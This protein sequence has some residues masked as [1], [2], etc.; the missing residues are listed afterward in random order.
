MCS[1]LRLLR[2]SIGL[3]AARQCVG[4]GMKVVLADVNAENLASAQQELED[5]G[6]TVKTVICDVSDM[7]SFQTLHEAVYGDPNFGECGF[8]FLNAGLAVGSSAYQSSMEDWKLQLGVNL[9]GVLHGLQLFTPAMVEQG[10]EGRIAA[11]SSFAGLVQIH[12]Q[13][14]PLIAISGDILRGCL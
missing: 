5:G 1:L 14:F 8:L 11:T 2:R 6:A 4:L 10:T 9:Y 13:I 3:A 12:A 7:A